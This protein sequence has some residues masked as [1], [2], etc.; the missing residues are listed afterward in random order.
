MNLHRFERVASFLRVDPRWITREVKASIER[1]M[2]FWP[3]A[4]P[5]LLGDERAGTILD[6][7]PELQLVQEA[8]KAA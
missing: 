8:F 6:R 2:E 1:A 5:A 7:L 3:D 4:A